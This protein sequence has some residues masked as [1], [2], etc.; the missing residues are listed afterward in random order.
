VRG[1]L[2]GRGLEVSVIS[3]S[4]SK[5]EKACTGRVA[6]SAIAGTRSLL[7]KGFDT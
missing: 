2:R 3:G 4:L 7:A 5:A 6:L 1:A